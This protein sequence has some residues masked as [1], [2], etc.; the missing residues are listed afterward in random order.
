MKHKHVSPDRAYR[1]S[2]RPGSGEV[3][4][5]VAVEQTDLLV[6][7]SS[8]LAVPM[9]REVALLRGQIKNHIIFHP[10]FAESLVPVEVEDGAPSIVRDM[11]EGARLCG[12]GP[13]AAVAGA[14][15]Q[16]VAEAFVGQSPDI[17]V[18]NGGDVFLA[19]S[20]ERVVALL[21]DPE[22]GAMVGLR[23]EV[24]RFPLS[25]CSSSA[26]IGHSLSLGEGEL[27]SVMAGN[28]AF[29]DAAATSLCNMLRGRE[30]LG[31]VLDEAK[32]LSEHG[33]EG[34]FVQGA[35]QLAVWGDVELVALD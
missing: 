11:A 27:V 24:D 13:M 22:S 32:R 6:V 28:A 35:G 12:V 26:T 29:A 15:A 20:R 1:D 4:F 33:L 25:V 8:D 17:I 23:L 14:V 19:S 16:H 34:V 30:S 7:A 10:E 5:Q 2:V 3:R 18:E 31:R 21:P 9:A